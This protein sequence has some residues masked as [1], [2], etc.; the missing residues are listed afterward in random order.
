MRQVL[1]KTGTDRIADRD[2][3]NRNVCRVLLHR[4]R[5][6]RAR[7]DNHVHFGR[8]QLG[9]QRR[10]AVVLSVG[11][12]IFD[13][14]VAAFLVAGV[15]Q[16]LAKRVKEIGFQRRGRVAHVA[17]KGSF[18]LRARGERPGGGRSTHQGNELPPSHYTPRLRY[19]SPIASRQAAPETRV[20]IS[21]RSN[22]KSMGLVRSASAPP[23]IALR[24][25]SASP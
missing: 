12:E 20:S 6:R 3:H 23:S 24:L 2:H 25:V 21:F 9:N 10:E 18:L 17:D 14:N 15:T 19:A 5:C 1:H 8:N 7:R 22:A 13:R 11:P 16:A 4:Q